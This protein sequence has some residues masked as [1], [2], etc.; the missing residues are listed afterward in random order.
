M[1]GL[2]IHYCRSKVQGPRPPPRTNR[3]Q[4]PLA[5]AERAPWFPWDQP[6][7]HW[8]IGRTN[9]PGSFQVFPRITNQGSRCQPGDQQLRCCHYTNRHQGYLGL[10]GILALIP[11][12]NQLWGL[13]LPQNRNNKEAFVGRKA[14]TKG[15]QEP[16]QV[17]NSGWTDQARKRAKG[18]RPEKGFHE[19]RV[20]IGQCAVEE[21]TR[22]FS[23]PGTRKGAPNPKNLGL[24]VPF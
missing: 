1:L 21:T 4:V 9:P 8:A 16:S 11:I 12:K 6:S 22:G 23:R 17:F 3:K 18:P 15:N 2:T 5:P 24:G 13:D 14:G 7:F 20:S 19:N 10:P